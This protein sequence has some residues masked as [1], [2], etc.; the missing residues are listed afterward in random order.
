[1]VVQIFV[2]ANNTFTN[3]QVLQQDANGNILGQLSSDPCL[4]SP[5]TKNLGS[6]KRKKWFTTIAAETSST[7]RLSFAQGRALERNTLSVGSANVRAEFLSLPELRNICIFQRGF[8]G[9][10]SRAVPHTS[11]VSP[12]PA[13]DLSRVVCIAAPLGIG[14][15]RRGVLSSV[16]PRLFSFSP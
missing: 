6:R 3:V 11:S 15:S 8:P 12:R 5:E 2:T 10:P 1:M 9:N 13:V 14:Y 4:L 7:S 16:A